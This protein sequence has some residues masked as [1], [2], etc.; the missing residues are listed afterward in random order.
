MEEILRNR[1][2]P[3][4]LLGLSVT[5][6]EA[7]IK[8]A[9]RV[10]CLKVHPDKCAHPSATL[11]FQ[12]LNDAMATLGDP[13]K[14]A[15]LAARQT[16]QEAHNARAQQMARLFPIVNQYTAATLKQGLTANRL[17]VSGNKGV[18]VQRLCTFALE[19]SG[20]NVDVASNILLTIFKAFNRQP[21]A[22]PPD[23]QRQPTEAEMTA[24]RQEAAARLAA[25]QEAA[26]QAAQKRAQEMAAWQEAA[27]QAAQQAAQRQAAEVA[28]RKE[29]T[30]QAVQQAA[31]RQA[32]EV[33]AR[34]EAARQAAQQA[35]QKHAA[36]LEAAQLAAQKRAA[37]F[38]ARQEAHRQ[39]VQRRAQEVAAR[40]EAAR[41]ESLKR[42]REAAAAQAAQAQAR[43]VPIR[44]Q[45]TSVT[46]KHK[47]PFADIDDGKGK[48]RSMKDFFGRPKPDGSASAST[49]SAAA[50]SPPPAASSSSPAAEAAHA[51][52]P[53][54][55]YSGPEIIELD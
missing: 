14:R 19:R 17:P 25:Q 48:Q 23:A 49:G 37:E 35:A 45:T 12:S 27:R 41:Q 26:R 31:Q 7:D 16:Q 10:R 18:L 50:A 6:T 51:R 24:Q 42:V 54:V 46:G 53:S 34:Q 43:K 32:A 11:A 1:A 52:M 47:R 2:D 8:K 29:A 44:Q 55:Y 22:P 13:A 38:A 30:R 5:A 3:F 33:A 39:E 36:R 40:Q 9:F 4:R 15:S 21:A 20:G 28:A